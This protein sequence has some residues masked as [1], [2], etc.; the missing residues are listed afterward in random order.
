MSGLKY[1]GKMYCYNQCVTFK[2]DIFSLAY[3]ARRYKTSIYIA[4]K[5][6]PAFLYE[7]VIIR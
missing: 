1:D 7:G 4:H 6:I 2:D 3:G 5:S